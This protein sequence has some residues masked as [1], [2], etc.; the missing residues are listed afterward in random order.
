M[1]W[2]GGAMLTSS[3]YVLEPLCSM[4]GPWDYVPG[5]LGLGGRNTTLGM[6]F[7]YDADT[8]TAPFFKIKRNWIFGIMKEFL[9]SFFRCDNDT[10]VLLK[11]TSFKT[12]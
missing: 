5:P 11:K 3:G 7:F 9:L 2:A 6:G 8:C 1:G 12:L 4:C 10:L